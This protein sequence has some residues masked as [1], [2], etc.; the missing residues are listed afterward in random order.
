MAACGAHL[1]DGTRDYRLYNDLPFYD[2]IEAAMIAKIQAGTYPIP[3]SEK[4]QVSP[5][6]VCV[7]VCLCVCGCMC[8][9]VCVCVSE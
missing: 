8:V 1:R 3:A 4:Y 2:D 5:E 6:G 9:Y 7:Y